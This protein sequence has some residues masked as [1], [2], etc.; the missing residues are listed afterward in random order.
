MNS[1]AEITCFTK[2]GGPLTKVIS[3]TA[4]GAVHS[5]G[6]ACIMWSGEA[7]RVEIT[8][9]DQLANLIGA[10]GSGEALALGAL[11]AGI[12]NKVRV[13]TKAKLSGAVNRIART[14]TDI[15]YRQGQSAFALLDFDTKG[16][17]SEVAAELERLGGFWPAVVSVL[18]GLADVARVTRHSTS[19]GL[20]RSD[21]KTKLPGSNNLH[22]Y[23]AVRD[24]A[25]IGRFLKTLH[26]RA[27]L[28]GL[29][30]Y[31][32][33]AGGQLLERSIID[34]SVG[35]P[36]RLVFEG[37]PILKS[38]IKQDRESRR[39]NAI[40]GD[41]LDTVLAC[42]PLSIAE[43]AKL[44]EMQAKQNHRLSAKAG[45]ARAAFIE[46]QAKQMAKRTGVST[47]A[48]LRIVGFQTE[49]ILL[50][51]VALP[52]DDPELEG[53]TVGDVLADPDRYTDETLA[54]PLEGVEYGRCKAK[55]M[56]RSDG[57][58]WIHSFAHG[59]TIYELKYD[60]RAVRLAMEQTEALDAVDV[61][62][63][64]V[65]R[66][67]LSEPELE[68][69]RDLAHERSGAGK[70]AIRDAI[71]EARREHAAD[72]AEQ[73]HQHRLATRTDPRPMIPEPLDDAPWL[74]EM[75]TINS[76]LGTSPHIKPPS[77]DIEGG[78]SLARRLKVPGTHA[79]E[80]EDHEQAANT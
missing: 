5:D 26:Q 48:A 57:T 16:M 68:E 55:I 47:S 58:P 28:A 73:R 66:A 29:G 70:K 42:P 80:G 40:D 62:I 20:F 51:L 24:G 32:V 17:P 7:R 52:F 75:D 49:Y 71:K 30:W 12:G 11:R 41:T 74:P 61:L 33:G 8:G 69:L 13:T 60:A 53:K 37:P 79:L 34:R 36:E 6:S 14:A 27:W 54:D 45:R 25:D 21:T 65:V 38:P 35:G 63:R 23:I 72:C 76:T 4:E 59:R 43:T 9:V 18:P 2:N 46:Q 15:V 44:Q 3:L 67:E 78:A 77:R 10:L 56:C 1:L 31:M 22:A 19:A 64:H 50:P 39:P